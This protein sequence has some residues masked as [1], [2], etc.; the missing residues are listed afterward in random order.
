MPV[1]KVKDENGKWVRLPYVVKIIQNGN[2][3]TGLTEEQ[4]KALNEM[5]CNID[6]NGDLNITYDNTVLDIKFE[7]DE[8]NL[9]IENNTNAIFDINDSGEL[10]VNYE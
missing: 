4:I 1:L 5:V 7:V 9:I 10:E 6:E 3:T 2:T 8:K